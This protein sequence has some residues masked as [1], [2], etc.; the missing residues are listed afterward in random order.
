MVHRHRYPAKPTNADF[1][2][3]IAI[4]TLLSNV[5]TV[6]V[7]SAETR[8][9]STHD[10]MIRPGRHPDVDRFD[11]V[12]MLVRNTFLL[13]IAPAVISFLYG[14]LRDPDLP[15]I[16]KTILRAI[17]K[18]LLGTLSRRHSENYEGKY[19]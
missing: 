16:I 19:L 6:V 1:S 14:V 13:A 17:K 15:F 12:Y 10:D 4:V 7:E 3:C 8:K 18:R 9:H 11:E 2:I 5:V